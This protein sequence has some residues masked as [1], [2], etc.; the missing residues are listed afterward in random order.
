MGKVTLWGSDLLASAT[1]CRP[2]FLAHGAS[3]GIIEKSGVGILKAFEF[4]ALD[5]LFYE[6]LNRFSKIEL[7]S[8][9]NSEGV[10]F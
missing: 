6:V 7:V 1:W 3:G 10:A 5:F 9:E 2:A 4:A 8:G